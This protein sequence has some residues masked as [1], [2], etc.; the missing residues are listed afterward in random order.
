MWAPFMLRQAQHEREILHDFNT[1][2]VRPEPVE[3]RMPI[4][5]FISKRSPICGA[6]QRLELPL[7]HASTSRQTLSLTSPAE[8]GMPNVRLYTK[9]GVMAQARLN[10]VIA[11][12]EQGKVVFGGG[13]A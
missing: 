8:A 11:L 5:R 13:M 6:G 7:E 10:K 2:P 1:T 4:F 12:L 9:E 3:G